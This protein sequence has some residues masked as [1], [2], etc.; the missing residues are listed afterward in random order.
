MQRF[1]KKGVS[2][3]FDQCE[4]VSTRAQHERTTLR[5]RR[6]RTIARKESHNL[7]FNLG[8]MF[9]RMSTEY[10]GENWF[11]LTF[12]LMVVWTV[13]VGKSEAACS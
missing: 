8:A 13:M 5:K 9:S 12:T 4:Y 2:L 3:I 6:Q 11:D 1:P 7:L 10:R